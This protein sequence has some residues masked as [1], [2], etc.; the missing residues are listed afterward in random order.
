VPNSQ[1]EKVFMHYDKDEFVFIAW[2]C[3]LATAAAWIT[4]LVLLII[5]DI[6]NA[7]LVFYL[8]LALSFLF[9]L[10]VLSYTIGLV[11][12]EKIVIKT[13]LKRVNA[14]RWDDV[15]RVELRF[16]NGD[17]KIG[18]GVNSSVTVGKA[19]KVEYYVF[20]S[21]TKK[22]KDTNDRANKE[23]T[24]IRLPRTSQTT[25]LISQYY[26]GDVVDKRPV[27]FGELL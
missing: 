26:Q 22:E 12:D 27:E 8:A 14:I 4:S 17:G 5:G 9:V 6:D 25:R 21:K 20:F 3:I 11:D 2:I 1:V 13:L 15:A 16:F 24:P 23:G 18:P 7:K 10:A 19:P